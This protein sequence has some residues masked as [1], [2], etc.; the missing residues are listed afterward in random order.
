MSLKMQMR[1]RGFGVSVLAIPFSAT[2]I[3]L[4]YFWLKMEKYNQFP[5]WFYEANFNSQAVFNKVWWQY[6]DEVINPIA[7]WLLVAIGIDLFAREVLKR[8][9][10]KKA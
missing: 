1:L 4:F 9:R 7:W 5:N 10:R 2:M 8:C 3:C 6:F